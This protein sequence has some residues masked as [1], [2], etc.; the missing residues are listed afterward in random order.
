MIKYFRL[1]TWASCQRIGIIVVHIIISVNIIIIEVCFMIIKV[2]YSHTVSILYVKHIVHSPIVILIVV[3]VVVIWCCSGCCCCSC[4]CCCGVRCCYLSCL[5]SLSWTMISKI[6][7]VV[8]RIKDWRQWLQV[9]RMSAKR[10][11]SWLKW[12]LI[13]RSWRRPGLAWWRNGFGS[14]FE[15]R[16]LKIKL[17]PY[18]H[19]S[20]VDCIKVCSVM[21]VLG[22]LGLLVFL[23][24]WASRWTVFTPVVF[25]G[26]VL[27]S[28]SKPVTSNSVFT[29]LSISGVKSDNLNPEMARPR[30][31]S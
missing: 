13:M 26:G 30:L 25:T 12:T 11:L 19:N 14:W 18:S 16:P 5:R 23:C 10:K 17:T 1:F 4:C 27:K 7:K 29:T 22:Y 2:R 31:W 9:V 15:P 24:E 21:V 28:R 8:P 3:I 6:V 20:L